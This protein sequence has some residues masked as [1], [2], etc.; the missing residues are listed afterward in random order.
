MKYWNCIF[1][2]HA[3]LYFKQFFFW[4]NGKLSVLWL[5]KFT[6][7]NFEHLKLNVFRNW[8]INPIHIVWANEQVCLCELQKCS[9]AYIQCNW[10]ILRWTKWPKPQKPKYSL[11]YSLSVTFIPGTLNM[12][13]LHATLS[14]DRKLQFSKSMTSSP[15]ICN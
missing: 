12:H 13:S 9:F 15:M 1:S 11:H 4:H 3:I 10:N 7:N 14:S 8:I 6:F 5:L 2:T